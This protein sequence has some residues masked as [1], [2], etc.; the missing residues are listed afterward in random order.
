MEHL[1]D[2][3]FNFVPL[4]PWWR[5]NYYS[6][7]ELKERWDEAMKIAQE[8]IEEQEEELEL[9]DEGRIDPN[10]DIHKWSD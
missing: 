6:M 10:E 1:N 8:N 2:K 4:N 3:Q 7:D 5:H 9:Q